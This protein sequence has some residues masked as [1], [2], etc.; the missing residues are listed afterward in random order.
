MRILVTFIFLYSI[1]VVNA[2][3][4]DKQF[5]LATE[6]YKNGNYAA[7]SKQFEAIEAAGMHSADLYYNIANSYFQQAALG[8]AIL[9][10]ERALQLAPSDKDI[11]HNLRVARYDLEDDI[12][13]LPPFFLRAWWNSLRDVL[14]SSTWAKL[15]LLLLWLGIAG[16]I[17]WQLALARSQRKLGFSLGIGLSLLSI[18][19][20]ALAYSKHQV[21]QHSGYGIIIN[22]E[23][24]LRHAAEA[25]SGKIVDLHEGTKV[26]LLDQ[27]STWHK[28]RLANGEEGWLPEGVF[29]EI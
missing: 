10:Y 29:E 28:I 26:Q 15:G 7:A 27:I 9:Y 11:Q 3:D 8:K 14:S 5:Q 19:P 24:A 6:A 1:L 22:K 23:I 20:F 25:D 4:Y 17:A 21:E 12:E 2:Q 16:L 13:A 18:L